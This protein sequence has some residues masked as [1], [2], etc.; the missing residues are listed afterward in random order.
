MLFLLRNIRRKMLSG[1]KITTYILYAI[2]EITLVVLGIL[3]AV[4]IDDSVAHRQNRA[5]ELKIL[6]EIITDLNK[7]IAEIDD[8]IWGFNI[9]KESDSLLVDYFFGSSEFTD[10]I[11][12]YIFTGEKSPH[13]NPISGGYQLLKSKGIDLVRHDSLRIA[14]TSYY[15][16]EIPY[17]Q[18]YEAERI[19]IVNNEI[20]PFNNQF[21]TIKKIDFFPYYCRVPFDLKTLKKNKKWISLVQKNQYL[22]ETMIS[23]AMDL[24]TSMLGLRDF[25]ESHLNTL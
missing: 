13:F 16:Q 14:I 9:L 3:I 25:I 8:D 23:K 17:Y 22:S 10:T 5:L 21:F 20:I 24:K 4:R 2:G 18:K 6:N 15:E 19:H 1:N 12:S 7:D 11:G